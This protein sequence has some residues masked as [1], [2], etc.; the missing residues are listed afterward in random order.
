MKLQFLCRSVEFM[1]VF[2]LIVT[3]SEFLDLRLRF[4]MIVILFYRTSL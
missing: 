3:V 2:F 1:S 4:S